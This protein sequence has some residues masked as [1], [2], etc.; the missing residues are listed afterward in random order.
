MIIHDLEI[1]YAFF[2]KDTYGL[3]TSFL[4]VT[5]N[6]P[7]KE[8]KIIENGLEFIWNTKHHILTK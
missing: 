5:D 8:E 6:T 4:N 2:F 7:N 1:L 3:L